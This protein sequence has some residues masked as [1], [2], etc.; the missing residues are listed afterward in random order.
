MKVPRYLLFCD[1]GKL[2]VQVAKSLLNFPLILVLLIIVHKN[3]CIQYFK[4]INQ[5]N[6]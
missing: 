5:L 6:S 2:S 3:H 4:V 1:I